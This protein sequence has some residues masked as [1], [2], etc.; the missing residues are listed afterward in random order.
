[1]VLYRKITDKPDFK[2]ESRSLEY[3]VDHEKDYTTQKGGFW[4]KE[5]RTWGDHILEEYWVDVDQHTVLRRNNSRKCNITSSSGLDI[6]MGTSSTSLL[7]PR[8]M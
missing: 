8:S 2:I 3:L 7:L 4:D 5:S 6:G 1:M